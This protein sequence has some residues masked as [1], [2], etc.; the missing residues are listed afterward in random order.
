[1]L[2]CTPCPY[3]GIKY[4]WTN[5]QDEGGLIM[6]KLDWIISNVVFARKWPDAQA[7]FMPKTMSDHSPMLLHIKHAH[8]Q[9]SRCFK[10]LNLWAEREDFLP[11]IA[12]IWQGLVNGSPMFRLS[13][14]LQWAKT[15]LQNWHKYHR[16]HIANRVQRAKKKWEDA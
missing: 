1:M 7:Q 2:N 11:H 12:S 16:T 10:F 9:P 8:Y 14:K 6:K 13:T 15:N 5:G 3:R 4:T